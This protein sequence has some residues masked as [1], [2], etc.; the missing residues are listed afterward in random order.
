MGWDG[1]KDGVIDGDGAEYWWHGVLHCF[2]RIQSKMSGWEL[3]E[4][5]TF[6]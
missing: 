2:I 1:R 4:I 3:R 5:L 6:L